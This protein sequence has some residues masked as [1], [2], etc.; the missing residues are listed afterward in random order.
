MGVSSTPAVSALDSGW[1][2]V[3]DVDRLPPFLISVV[4]PS[5]H[6]LYA[7]SA[8]GLDGA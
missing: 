4:S 6:W 2:E 1:V 8:G 3:R 7:S 5:D